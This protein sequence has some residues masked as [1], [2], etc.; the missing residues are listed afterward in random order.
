MGGPSKV[1]ALLDPSIRAL[2]NALVTSVGSSLLMHGSQESQP[3]VR[4]GNEVG[5]P[6]APG[7]YVRTPPEETCR[8]KNH[9]QYCLVVLQLEYGVKKKKAPI[10]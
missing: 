3:G 1:P 6:P 10:K 2:A 5:F 4:R 7:V 8:L 9:I